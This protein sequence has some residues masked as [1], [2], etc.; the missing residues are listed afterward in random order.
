[1]NLLLRIR[2]TKSYAT[3]IQLNSNHLQCCWHLCTPVK[4]HCRIDGVGVVVL[5]PP[6]RAVQRARDQ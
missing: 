3:H 2:S 6:A 1:M 4:G 5:P